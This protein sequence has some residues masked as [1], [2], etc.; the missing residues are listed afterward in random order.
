MEKVCKQCSSKFMV[1]DDDLKFYDKI[2]LTIVG[3]KLSIPA[4]DF[5]TQCRQQQILALRN[6]MALYHRKCDLCNAS[7]ISMFPG[8]SR[9]KVYCKKCWWGDKWNPLDYGK[10]FDFS[11][12]FFE[13]FNELI[14]TVPFGHLIIGGEVENCDYTNYL[15]TSKNCYLISSSDYDEDCYYS[16][17]IFRSK[18]C[19]D[20]LFVNDSELLC[21]CID[22]NNCY[23]SAFLQDCQNVSN[24]Y[25]CYDCKS[26]QNCIG[27]VGLRNK[28]YHIMDEKY[29][30]EEFEKKKA[31]FFKE[32]KNFDVLRK[33]FNEF[34]LKFP[35]KFAEIEGCANSDGDR[36]SNCKNAHNCFDLIEAQDCK[37]VA[38]GL[39]AKD[40]SDCIGVPNSELCYLATASPED[41]AIHFSAVTWPKSTY[42]Q[43]CMFCRMS[44]NCFGCVSLYKNQYCILNKQYTKEQ[45]E[46]L[47]P[48]IIEHMKKTGEYGNFFP[49]EISPFAYNETAANDHFPMM[50][51]EVIKKGLRW[52]EDESEK[53]YKGPNVEIPETISD[54]SEDICKKILICEMTGKPYKIIPQEFHFYKK[55]SLP[56]PK[57]CPDQRHKDRMSLRNPRKLWDRKCQKCGIDIKTSYSPERPEIVYCEKCYLEQAY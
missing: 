12:P 42:L 26:C 7:I 48:K 47:L 57:R 38:L 39:K 24:S 10:D 40:C 30:Q 19:F 9:V 37:N 51:E 5:C 27:C 11:R 45:Y 41:Y 36:L 16:T 8:V 56:L 4:P 28:K 33:Q 18:N 13:Q 6:E 49:M 34:R 3:E 54:A 2:S 20:C 31:E 29:S 14:E 35:H 50:K 53:M 1:T 55:M 22:S 21:Q 32:N 46:E 25:F 23:S 44:N 43:Y 52:H 15:M 17:Y